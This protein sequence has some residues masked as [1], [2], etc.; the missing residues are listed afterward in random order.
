MERKLNHH[1]LKKLTNLEI[2]PALKIGNNKMAAAQT[3]SGQ[4]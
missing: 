2:L 3:P 4:V 1:L